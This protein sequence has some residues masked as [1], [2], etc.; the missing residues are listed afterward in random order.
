LQTTAQARKTATTSKFQKTMGIRNQLP[1]LLPVIVLVHDAWH[2]PTH[3]STFIDTLTTLG[4]AIACPQLLTAHRESNC[5]SSFN[6]DCSL[7]YQLVFDLCSEGND[8][9]VIGHGYGAFIAT[10]VLGD[11]SKT[12]REHLDRTGGVIGLVGLAGLLPNQDE[13]LKDVMTSQNGGEWPEYIRQQV[14]VSLPIALHK[15]SVTHGYSEWQLT[16]STA[17][18]DTSLTL[19]QPCTFLYNDLGPMD[20][21]HWA[22]HLVRFTAKPFDILCSSVPAWKSI[23]TTYIICEDDYFLPEEVQR[24][25]A[26]NAGARVVEMEDAG[27]DAFIGKCEDLVEIIGAIVARLYSPNS[28]KDNPFVDA[29]EGGGQDRKDESDA[30]SAKSA[31]EEKIPEG[32]IGKPLRRTTTAP[33]VFEPFSVFC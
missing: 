10:E 13:T 18:K 30:D 14:P 16:N 3:Y 27:H 12:E 24:A 22:S 32:A 21:E 19:I 28:N 9:V 26:D 15:R 31:P 11:L 2:M 1:E 29:K 23:P 33:Y 4:Y 20:G 7:I 17:K 8:V 25:I 6:D 5:V